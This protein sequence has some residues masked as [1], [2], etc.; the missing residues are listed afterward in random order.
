MAVNRPTFHEAWYRVAQ[1]C[2][3]L[4]TSVQVYRQHFRGQMWYVLENATN[5]TFSRISSSAYQFVAQLD[6]RRNVAQ[7]WKKCNEQLSLQIFVRWVQSLL[8]RGTSSNH[9]ENPNKKMCGFAEHNYRVRIV[10]R[11]LPFCHALAGHGE[12]LEGSIY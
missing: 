4:L 8:S 9:H 7:V 1:L 6:G 11:W 3:R 2:P 10:Y 5:N 12:F